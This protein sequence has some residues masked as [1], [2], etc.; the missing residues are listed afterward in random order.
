M[1]G[2]PRTLPKDRAFEPSKIPLGEPARRLVTEVLGCIAQ[3][4]DRRRTR[5]SV[6]QDL[7]VKQATALV[8]DLA[9]LELIDPGGWLSVSLKKVHYATANRSAPFLTETFP[10]L[11]KLL[12]TDAS[13]VDFQLGSQGVFNAGRRTAIRAGGSLRALIDDLEL[14][15]SDIGRD[16]VLRGDVLVLKGRKIAGKARKLAFDETVDTRRM[17]EE[18]D[19]INDWLARADL[20]WFGDEAAD[21]IDSGDRFLKR[22]FNDGRFDSGG[23]LFGGFWQ[24]A[25]S[26]DRL[27]NTMIEGHA[28]AALDFGQMAVRIAYSMQK[29]RPPHGDDLY[30]VPGLER[31]RDGVKRVLNALLAADAIPQRFPQGSRKCFPRHLRFKEVREAIE[32]HHPALK[33]LFGTGQALRIMKIESDLLVAIL[34]RLKEMGVVALP[35]HDCVLVRQKNESTAKSVMEATFRE[36]LGVEGRVEIKRSATVGYTSVSPSSPLQRGA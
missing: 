9:H 17:R 10:K 34:L 35:I 28:A 12:S 8:L 16:R 25:K 15:L 1:D 30:V 21:R 5:R 19:E 26:D 29:V 27:D 32:S 36:I 6:D 13:L 23:R 24:R 3:L 7:H 2:S 18:I 33:P 31:F 20:F 11:V 22:I 4:E 14:N